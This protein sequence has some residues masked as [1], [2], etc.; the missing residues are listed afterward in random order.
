MS[1]TSREPWN[2]RCRGAVATLAFRTRPEKSTRRPG[3]RCG[4]QSVRPVRQ[5]GSPIGAQVEPVLE[6][7][8][9]PPQRGAERHFRQ[10]QTAV[11]IKSPFET[12][13]PISAIR[14]TAE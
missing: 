13:S 9:L 3:I 1:A 2:R 8:P 12:L 14:Q 7:I 4:T 11:E 5:H 6:V 10:S